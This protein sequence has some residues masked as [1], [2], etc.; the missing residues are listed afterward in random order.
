MSNFLALSPPKT[1]KV[2]PKISSADKLTTINLKVVEANKILKENFLFDKKQLA[3]RAKQ[4]EKTDRKKEE[5]ELETPPETSETTPAKGLGIKMPKS[6]FLDGVKN[7]IFTVLI[8]FAATRLLKFLPAMVKLLKPLA[9]IANFFL[10]VGG[11][12]VKSLIAFLDAGVKA[13]DFTRNAV[14]KT[15]GEDG[16]KKFDSFIGNLSKFLNLVMTVGMTAAAVSMAM[17]DQ[18]M[19]DGKPRPK[20]KPKPK[21]DPKDVKNRAKNIKR[22]RRQ[23]QLQKLA[24]RFKKPIAIKTKL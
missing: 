16:V 19:G 4:L 14:K 20:P 7:F 3:E 22:I 6:K 13:F 8:G 11:V 9:A 17:A 21:F 24:K 18:S 12:I 2:R 1:E 15:F 23:K 5:S 10:K